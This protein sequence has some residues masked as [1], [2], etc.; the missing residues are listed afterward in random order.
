MMLN[1]T[2]QFPF[3][4]LKSTLSHRVALFVSA[5][6]TDKPLPSY[7]PSQVQAPLNS[8]NSTECRSS[9]WQMDPYWALNVTNTLSWYNGICWPCLDSIYR[10]PFGTASC[11]FPK[12]VLA[13]KV[14]DEISL[15][16]D[17]YFLMQARTYFRLINWNGFLHT[18]SH[19]RNQIFWNDFPPSMF[20]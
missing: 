17:Q 13:P 2:L 16:Q 12:P 5:K 18:N 19:G 15:Q 3:R 4:P 14:A 20:L 6:V 8:R 11:I 10:F 1:K 7:S 9:P